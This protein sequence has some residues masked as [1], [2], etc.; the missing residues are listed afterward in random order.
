MFTRN[1]SHRLFTSG[2]EVS[3]HTTKKIMFPYAKLNTYVKYNTMSIKL[4]S[5]KIR[6]NHVI[7]LAPNFTAVFDVTGMRKNYCTCFSRC[8]PSLLT[9]LYL[10]PPPL[11]C[12]FSLS[13]VKVFHVNST[14]RHSEH[15]AYNILHVR[16]LML[17]M[18]LNC[19][20]KIRCQII[21]LTSEY[22][23]HNINSLM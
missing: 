17:T 13:S 4:H 5:T 9:I 15:N 22:M 19:V 20:F 21:C 14:H 6:N 1:V 18:T 7:H 8:P 11:L 23:T 2:T 12:Y 10:S 16:Q 3:L